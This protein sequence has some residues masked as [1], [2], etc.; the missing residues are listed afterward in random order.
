MN[1]TD[2]IYASNFLADGKP[3][4]K[5]GAKLMKNVGEAFLIWSKEETKK[6]NGSFKKVR[7]FIDVN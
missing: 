1:T 2:N 5:I 6:D 7:S 4:L 3:Q